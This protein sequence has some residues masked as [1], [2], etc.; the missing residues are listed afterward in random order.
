MLGAD[1]LFPVLIH[2]VLQT[3]PPR[4]ASTL[5]YV[6]RF[7]SPM[8]LK[9]E[10]GC[11]FTHLQAAVTFL[12]GLS[13]EREGKEREAHLLGTLL[14]AHEGGM[15]HSPA[16]LS[17]VSMANDEGPAPATQGT[18]RAQCAPSAAP[19]TAT[20]A[21]GEE[22]GGG[23]SGE[24]R[25][26]SSFGSMS[27]RSRSCGSLFSRDSQ[28]SLQTFTRAALAARRT[29]TV[30]HS[31]SA[32]EQQI[33]TLHMGADVLESAI[34]ATYLDATCR[35]ASQSEHKALSRNGTLAYLHV[36]KTHRQC[37]AAPTRRS[38]K[39]AP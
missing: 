31:T 14:D 32:W 22:G 8:A 33:E 5:A 18:Q 34:N 38:C 16:G 27:D 28:D 6:Q 9:S 35:Q 25:R 12:E 13:V 30:E 23:H 26:S 7:R 24:A 29:A 15:T 1:E 2:I 17:A 21:A 20:T 19:S 4:L 3:N 11:Y 39:A 10:A 37:A 36:G